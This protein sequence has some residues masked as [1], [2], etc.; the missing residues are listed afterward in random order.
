MRLGSLADAHGLRRSDPAFQ[1]A[2]LLGIVFVSALVGFAQIGEDYVTGDAP[3]VRKEVVSSL[4]VTLA[5]AYLLAFVL[6]MVG[7]VRRTHPAVLRPRALIRNAVVFSVPPVRRVVGERDQLLAFKNQFPHPPGHF[8]SPIPDWPTVTWEGALPDSCAGID[9]NDAA[10]LGLLRALA[11][12]HDEHPFAEGS[13]PGVRYFYESLEPAQGRSLV[14]LR[15]GVCEQLAQ[16]ERIGKRQP[17]HLSRGLRGQKMP[18]I[19]RSLKPTVGCPPRRHSDCRWG[20]GLRSSLMPGA[21]RLYRLRTRF[22][23]KQTRG[24]L[25]S[26]PLCQLRHR[27]RDLARS[28]FY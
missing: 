16:Q 15:V 8:Y 20:D 14:T 11:Q 3:I 7:H 27:L 13:R 25:R 12:F 2:V 1:A 5:A 24:R 9:L 21:A 6:R 10:Q 18:T 23:M 26:R 4:G 17:A 28:L 22:R 19:D